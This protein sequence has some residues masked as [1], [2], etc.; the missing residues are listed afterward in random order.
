MSEKLHNPSDNNQ[1]LNRTK[2]WVPFRFAAR[3]YVSRNGEMKNDPATRKFNDP[4]TLSRVCLCNHGT[5]NQNLDFFLKKTYCVLLKVSKSWK[6]IMVSSILLKNEQNSLSWAS[7][8]LRIVIFGRI[9]ET[10]IYFQDCLT[11]TYSN[12][13][14]FWSVVL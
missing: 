7:S 6:Q 9:G 13:L 14:F 10:M 3:A 11:F 12:S 4:K 1:R 2:W 8:L 5:V